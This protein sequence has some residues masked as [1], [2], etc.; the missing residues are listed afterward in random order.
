M[1]DYFC[2]Q[3]LGSDARHAESCAEAVSVIKAKFI[4]GTISASVTEQLDAM[5]NLLTHREADRAQ[6]V[7][8]VLS[9]DSAVFREHK[10]WLTKL[11]MLT[12]LVRKYA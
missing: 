2:S 12:T 8:R 10:D 11:R 3:N 4:A 6:E 9:T 5:A 1:V 7:L